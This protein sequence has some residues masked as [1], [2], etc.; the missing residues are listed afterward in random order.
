MYPRPMPPHPIERTTD[1]V[2]VLAQAQAVR[3]EGHKEC[4]REVSL[5]GHIVAAEDWTSGGAA[6][7]RSPQRP[8]LPLAPVSLTDFLAFEQRVLEKLRAKAELQQRTA[9]PIRGV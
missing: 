5:K 2:L 8:T 4:W 3:I 6:S 1:S 7:P 9:S